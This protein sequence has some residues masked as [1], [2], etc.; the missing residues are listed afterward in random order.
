MFKHLSLFF[1]AAIVI[2]ACSEKENKC[3]LITPTI[4]VVDFTIVDQQGHTLIGDS[5]VYHPD[6][7]FV[8]YNNRP[9]SITNSDSVMRFNFEIGETSES[10]LLVLNNT[11]LDTLNITYYTEQ[12]ECFNTYIAN[13]FSLNGIPQNKINNTFIIRK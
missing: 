4:P 10:Y 13:V 8:L 9:L 5:N 6:S 1:I 12:G 3:D 2:V 11:E 7:I